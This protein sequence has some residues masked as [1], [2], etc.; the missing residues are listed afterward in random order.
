MLVA[1]ESSA[2]NTKSS[3]LILVLAFLQK[4]QQLFKHNLNMFSFHIFLC[5]THCKGL[6]CLFMYLFVCFYEED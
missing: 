5:I 3:A 4:M 1:P 6:F 2:G